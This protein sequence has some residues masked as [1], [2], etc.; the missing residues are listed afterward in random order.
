LIIESEKPVWLPFMKFLNTYF[1]PNKVGFDYK[2]LEK[3][4]NSFNVWFSLTNK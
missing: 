4:V 3:F 1:H 2:L